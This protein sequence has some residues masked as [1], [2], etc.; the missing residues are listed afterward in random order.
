MD[1]DCTMMNARNIQNTGKKEKW[2]MRTG[3]GNWKRKNLIRITMERHRK[4]HQ[5]NQEKDRGD[6]NVH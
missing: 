1:A 3:K 4:H 5:Q 2:C 6:G